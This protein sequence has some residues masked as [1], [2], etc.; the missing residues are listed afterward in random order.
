MAQRDPKSAPPPTP[1]P[2]TDRTATRAVIECG[3]AGEDVAEYEALRQAMLDHHLPQ[4]PIE[5]ELVD[6][7]VDLSW[8][9]RRIV[10]VERGLATQHVLDD[11]NRRSGPS[12]DIGELLDPE[13]EIVDVL[14]SN[15]PAEIALALAQV[16][17][18][19]AAVEAGTLQTLAEAVQG[20][21]SLLGHDSDDE[22]QPEVKQIALALAQVESAPRRGKKR[23]EASPLPDAVRASVIAALRTIEDRLR[24]RAVQARAWARAIRVADVE[25]RALPAPY[26]LKEI[27]RYEAHV[28]DCLVRTARTLRREQA[29]RR[30]R[31]AF[32]RLGQHEAGFTGP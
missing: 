14:E 27:A 25:A 32:H 9:L 20:L 1:T 23:T 16:E 28:E 22:R 30:L 8:R 2:A 17:A 3:D 5:E 12:F 24:F 19:R 7:L 21:D 29:R 31:Q 11:D 13:V 4:G 10:R 18:L 15:D 6:R 26:M